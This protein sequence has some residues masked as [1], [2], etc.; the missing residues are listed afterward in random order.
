MQR[1]MNTKKMILALA[2]GAVAGTASAQISFGPRTDLATA[3]RPSGIASADFTG[4]GV[5]DLAVIVDTND[6]ILV[7]VGDGAGGFTPGPITFLGSGVGADA[8][9]NHDVDGDGDQD[10]I[11]VLDGPNQARVML[12]NGGGTF[13][14]GGSAPTQVEPVWIVKGDLNG[15]P[16]ADFVV[17]NRDSSSVSIMLDLGASFA[18][19]HIPVGDEPRSVAIADF[20]GDGLADLA[21][22][23]HDDRTVR[24][25]N[26]NGAGGFTPGQVIS[27]PGER[28]EGVVAADFD[29]DG[30]QDM[31]ITIEGSVDVYA[32][33]GGTLSRAL[34]LPVGSIDPSEMYVGDF[35]PGTASGPDILVVNNDGGSLSVFENLGGLGFGAALVLPVGVQPSFTTVG[36]FDGNGSGDIAVTNRD[37]N[38]TSVFINDAAGTAPCPADFDGD[39]A[40]TL[41]DFLAFQSAFDTMDPRAD[42]DGDGAFTV[43]DFLDFQN[44]FSAGCP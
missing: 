30:D 17:V 9:I 43:F 16:T 28:A 7:M 24:I 34:R 2:A 22:T 38:T 40:L 32:N 13:V 5:M 41:F 4:D 6:R 33:N 27:T 15:N 10:L 36:D 12:N 21:V 35:A 25:L 11:V 1:M 42:I 14:A 29:G 19:T 39:G 37:S 23:S 20:T 8:A 3:Q 31:A 44:L 18:S 26:G